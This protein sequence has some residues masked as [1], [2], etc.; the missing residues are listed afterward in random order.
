MASV[1]D[2]AEPEKKR[3]AEV[4][5]IHY[6]IIESPKGPTSRGVC[7]YC[8]AVREFKNYMPY[9]TWEDGMPTPNQGSGKQ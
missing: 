9:P 5:C 7:K 8:G 3:I 1:L 4:Q 2:K 6:W